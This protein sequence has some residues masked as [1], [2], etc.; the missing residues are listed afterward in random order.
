MQTIYSMFE[1]KLM[2][3]KFKRLLNINNFNCRIKSS[4]K[5][6]FWP[7]LV[8]QCSVNFEMIFYDWNRFF[9]LFRGF[10]CMLIV[11]YYCNNA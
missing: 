1:S 2:T 4:R 11:L 3:K 9:K 6:S 10:K 7:I 5:C 8:L